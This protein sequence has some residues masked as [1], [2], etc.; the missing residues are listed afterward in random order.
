MTA[1][2]AQV[3]AAPKLVIAS[4]P[5]SPRTRRPSIRPTSISRTRRPKG[6][7]SAGQGRKTGQGRAGARF[8]EPAGRADRPDAGGRGG[9]GNATAAGLGEELLAGLGPEPRRGEAAAALTAGSRSRASVICASWPKG[10]RRVEEIL[11]EAKAGPARGQ[12]YTPLRFGLPLCS[13]A[14]GR[15]ARSRFFLLVLGPGGDKVITEQQS[16][17]FGKLDTEVGIV[18]FSRSPRGKTGQD[19]HRSLKPDPREQGGGITSS[20]LGPRRGPRLPAFT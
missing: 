12:V 11:D 5:P 9:G 1:G 19:L 13:R 6:T 14:P 16:S 20:S 17:A 3:G 8:P 10:G 15:T 2:P 7:R 4:P 18:L